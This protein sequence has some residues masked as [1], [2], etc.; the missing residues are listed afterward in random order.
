MN[1]KSGVMNLRGT[2][3]PLGVPRGTIKGSD[4]LF[5]VF[6]ARFGRSF[7]GECLGKMSW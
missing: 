5:S 1:F 2:F 4:G 7:L 3:D 6:M